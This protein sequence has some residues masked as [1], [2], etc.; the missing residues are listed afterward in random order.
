VESPI[1]LDLLMAGG[2][3]AVSS[4]S[5]VF[6]SEKWEAFAENPSASG[7]KWEWFS[8]NLPDFSVN[9]GSFAGKGRRFGEKADRFA[10]KG[11]AFVE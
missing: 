7:E 11:A 2:F 4:V 8:V 6:S 3:L 9:A 5:L 1:G 10:E